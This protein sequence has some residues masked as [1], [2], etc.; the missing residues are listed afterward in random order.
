MTH[1]THLVREECRGEESV[2]T[3]R[4]DQNHVSQG[5]IV[6]NV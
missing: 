6:K 1:L 3:G 5:E 4:R 2:S